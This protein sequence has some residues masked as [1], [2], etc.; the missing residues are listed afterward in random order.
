MTLNGNKHEENR[1]LI[2]KCAWCNEKSVDLL[3]MTPG[4]GKNRH[5]FLSSPY[6]VHQHCRQKLE[7]YLDRYRKYEK[8]F[9]RAALYF[10]LAVVAGMIAILVFSDSNRLLALP[11]GAL[12]LMGIALARFP[13]PTPGTI[14]AFG[15]KRAKKLVKGIGMVMGLA[16][17]VMIFLLG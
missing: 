12:V 9:N 2:K 4:R 6:Y 14:S 17:A 11:A 10:P 5:Q 15:I 7:K 16:G 3:E 13:F 8:Y 1:K